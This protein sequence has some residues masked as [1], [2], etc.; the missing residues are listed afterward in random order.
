MPV[1]CGPTFVQGRVTLPLDCFCC[2]AVVPRTLDLEF[3]DGG[4]DPP[5]IV[6][7]QF[8]WIGSDVFLE[9]MHLGGAWDRGDPQFPCQQ[10]REGDLS[11]S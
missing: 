7:R 11:A 10:P 6:R 8:D 9:T 1:Q 2:R 3:R 5:Q 4:L